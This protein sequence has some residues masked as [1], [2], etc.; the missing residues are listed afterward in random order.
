MRIYGNK[1]K[2]IRYDRKL[3]D[4]AIGFRDQ[5]T[6]A[7]K[8][9]WQELKA[10][11]LGYK[12]RRQHPLHRF[13]VD[14][15]CYELMLVVEIDGSIHDDQKNRDVMRDKLLQKNGFIILRFTN[16]QVF[17]DL[18]KVVAKIKSITPLS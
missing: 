13:I 1:P 17:Y 3:R 2:Q 9:L 15:Y 10:K 18:E 4:I 16:D 14:F 6:S 12:F 8:I 7:E 11:K 5:P